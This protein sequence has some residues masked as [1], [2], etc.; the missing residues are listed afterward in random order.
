M[1]DIIKKLPKLRGYRFKSPNKKIVVINVSSLNV[2]AAG[3]KITPEIVFEKGL[4]RRIGGVYPAVKILGSGD[5]AVKLDVIG[6]EVS[7]SAK[8]KIEKAGGS[9]GK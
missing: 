4:I 9:I 6:F 7:E 2:F 8:A 1:R 5:L 3:D